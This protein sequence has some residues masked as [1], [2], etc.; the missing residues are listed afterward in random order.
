MVTVPA[1]G[2]VVE[3]SWDVRLLAEKKEPMEEYARSFV[4]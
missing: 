3:S 4:L 2:G 1:L